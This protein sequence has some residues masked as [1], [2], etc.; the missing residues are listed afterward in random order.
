MVPPT[1][2]RG[3]GRGGA[4]S[5][6]NRNTR[7]STGTS[8]GA[9]R[10]GITKRGRAPRTDRDGDLDMGAASSARSGAG[11]QT[12][13]NTSSRRGNT[14]SSGPRSSSRLQ[15]N[16]DRHL[17]GDI[18]QIPRGPAGPRAPVSNTTLKIGGV[19]SSKAASNT[20]GGVKSLVDFVEKKATHIKN[21][22]ARTNGT[23]GPVRPVLIKK[24]CQGIQDWVREVMQHRQWSTLFNLP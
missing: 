10:S 18:S 15:Q 16:L 17:G 22:D 7:T 14:R 2:P 19:K 20:D 9:P 21:K 6:S 11:P 12:T 4:G 24:V 13:K 1:G 8:R 3:G 23:R 5:S